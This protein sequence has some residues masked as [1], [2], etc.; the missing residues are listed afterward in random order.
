M[1]IGYLILSETSIDESISN[2]VAAHSEC[3]PLFG[4][5]L[6]QTNDTHLSGGVVSLAEVT[7][8]T[9]R[10]GDLS[11][12]ILASKSNDKAKLNFAG[13]DPKNTFV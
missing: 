9:W 5:R 11:Y 7:V 3:T 13:C 1:T 10:G 4:D 12:K 6:G 8:Q 2:S